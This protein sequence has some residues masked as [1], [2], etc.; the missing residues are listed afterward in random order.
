MHGCGVTA[1]KTYSGCGFTRQYWHDV[2]LSLGLGLTIAVQG[3]AALAVAKSAPWVS[4]DLAASV[5]FL[6]DGYAAAAQACSPME[7]AKCAS[8]SVISSRAFLAA[9]GENFR[10]ALHQT[11]MSR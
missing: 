2:M 3:G 5:R 1:I 6:C 4:V 10:A 8:T 11:P 9:D 7:L